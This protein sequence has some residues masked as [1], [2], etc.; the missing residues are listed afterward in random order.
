MLKKLILLR[1]AKS[2]PPDHSVSDIDRVLNKKGLQ[3]AKRMAAHLA[4]KEIIPDLVISSPARRAVATAWIFTSY[5]EYPED[6]IVIDNEIYG[7]DINNLYSVIHGCDEKLKK[8]MIVGHN[9]GITNLLDELTDA[10][11]ADVPSC[12]LAVI[13]FPDSE[14]Y[15]VRRNS[16][17]LDFFDIPANYN[18]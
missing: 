10:G 8:L 6:S 14:W 18:L 16:G 15:T 2:N 7:A 13:S 5:L 1:H 3:D 4:K 11:I 12:G 9:P 17:V